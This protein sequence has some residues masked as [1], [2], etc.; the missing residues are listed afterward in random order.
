[1]KARKLYRDSDGDMPGGLE[2]VFGVDER[3]GKPFAKVYRVGADGTVF[4]TVAST[5]W[6]PPKQA[7][8]HQIVYMLQCMGFDVPRT[9]VNEFIKAG[10]TPR[11]S[12]SRPRL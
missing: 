11:P 2:A 1:M 6:G 5:N 3:T 9:A 8:S 7:R 10:I 12:M 4:E